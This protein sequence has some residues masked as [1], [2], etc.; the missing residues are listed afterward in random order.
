MRA[1]NQ[2]EAE[3]YGALTPENI[4]KLAELDAI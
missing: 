3:L 2:E 1:R 4:I